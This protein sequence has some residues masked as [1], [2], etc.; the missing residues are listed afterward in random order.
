MLLL[1]LLLVAVACREATAN[2]IITEREDKV[3]QSCSSP[4]YCQGELLD[5]I[6]RAKIFNDSKTFVDMSQLNPVEVTLENFCWTPADFTNSPAILQKINDKEVLQFA[7]NLIDIWPSLGRKISSDVYLNPDQHSILEV[8]NGF[9]VP[10]G[11]F[12]ELYYWDSYWIIKGLLLSDMYATVRGMLEN[13]CYLINQFGFMPNGSR[14]YYLNRSQP[15]LFTLMIEEY[16][17]YTQDTDWLKNNIECIEAELTFWLNNRTDVVEK[18]GV[19]YELAHFEPLSNTPRPESYEKDLKTCS[20][21]TEEKDQKDCYKSIKSGAETGW[22]FSSRWFFDDSGGTDTNLTHIRAQRVVPVDLNAFL[23]RAFS[24]LAEF[25]ALLNNPDKQIKWQERSDIWQKSI[26]M[27][28][29]DENEGIWLDYDPVLKRSRNYFYPSNFAP[30]WAETYELSKREE[31][32]RRAAAYFVK[33]EIDQFLGGVPTS[34]DLSGEQW[35]F[36]NAWPP[37]QEFVVLGLLQT[38]N[39]NATEIATLFGQRWI[40]SNIEGY[41]ENQIMFEKYDALDPGKFGGGGEYEKNGHIPNGTI[42]NGVNHGTRSHKKSAIDK[43]RD[44]TSVTDRHIKVSGEVASLSN[45][46]GSV[47][48]FH[49]ETTDHEPKQVKRRDRREQDKEREAHEYLQRLETDT[50]RLKSDLQ[51]SRASEQDLRLQVASLTTCEKSTKGELSL[52][53]RQVDDLQERL[54][55]A[56]SAKQTDKQTIATLERRLTEE[57]RLRAN[58]DSQLAQERKN[59]K[60]EE[61]RLAQVTAQQSSRTE[62]TDLCKAR[63][64]E[65]EAELTECRQ[66]QRWA[67]ERCKTHELEKQAIGEQAR[68][69]ELL[70]AALSTVQE[71][72]SHLENA[73]SA[74]TRIKLDLFSALGDAKRHLEI[75]QR[76]W[77]FNFPLVLDSLNTR[78]D[79]RIKANIDYCLIPD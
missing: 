39:S 58:V 55:N 13:I 19:N 4:I 20:V 57:R 61:A 75:S 69:R 67:E 16:L 27:V 53:Q 31:Y 22:D 5:V 79:F 24:H 49:E 73:L 15:P 40:S 44:H 50:R 32:G 28:F 68:D 78:C 33:Q 43:S 65:L 17:K 46:N 74:E 37:L 72:N 63:R 77:H 14:L 76:P 25:Y 52:L 60:Q 2:P 3:I 30:L 29:Y 41:R 71:K 9:I 36:R 7:K 8:P 35:D 42:P 38:G 1:L 56:Q 47:V 45:L 64:R 12:R 70:M 6:Q 23:C 26:Q 51:Q 66:A 54:Q 21:Y 59:R 10:G 34:L 11:R 18:D 48:D 62:C